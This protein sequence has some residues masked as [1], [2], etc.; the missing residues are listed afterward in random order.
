MDLQNITAD[1]R[2]KVGEKIQLA[3]EGLG[4]FRVFT[5]FM[6]E[7]GDHLAIVLKNEKGQWILTDE[8]H[9]FMH[10]TYDIEEKDFQK[11][12]RYKIISNALS[13]FSVEDREGELIVRI[14]DDRFGDALFS[15]IQGLL[16]ITDVSYLARETVRSTFM[17]DFRRLIESA[18]PEERRSFDWRDPHHD[19]EGNYTVDCRINGMPR[20]IFIQAIANDDKARDATITLLQFEKWRVPHRSI[21]IFEDQ[22]EINRKVLARFSD[23]GDKMFSSLAGNDERII[24]YLKAEM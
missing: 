18:V 22:K 17:E 5:P 13:M 8:G 1:F 21:A 10:L 19:P 11:G 2:A 9:T 20:P 16:K 3:P 7:D 23:I 12:T 14:P 6:F 4:R 15:Y 24:Q